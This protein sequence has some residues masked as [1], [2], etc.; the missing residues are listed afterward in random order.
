MCDSTR[1]SK[2]RLNNHVCICGADSIFDAGG[3]KND[4]SKSKTLVHDYEFTYENN[5]TFYFPNL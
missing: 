5:V 3:H 2:I 1:I 4:N